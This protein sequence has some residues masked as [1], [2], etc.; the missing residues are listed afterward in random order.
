MLEDT[1]QSAHAAALPPPVLYNL[2]DEIVR[3]RIFLRP[4]RPGDGAAL[5]E[6]VEESREHLRPWL[7]WTDTYRTPNDAEASARRFQARWILREDMVVGVWDRASGRF[8]GGAGLHPAEWDVPSFEIGYWLRVS[9]QGFGYITDAAQALCGLAFDTFSANRVFIRCDARNQRSANVA[10]RLGFTHE[11]TFR[12][13]ARNTAGELR[14]TLY[15]GLTPQQHA[16]LRGD[17]TG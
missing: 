2:P 11:A 4:Y 8:V 7:P 5:W 6:A 14:D 9:A 13:E 15:F 12:N 17:Y 16:Q 10:R 3:Q 1:E